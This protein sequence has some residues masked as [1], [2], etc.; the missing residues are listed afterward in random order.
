[1]GETSPKF[2]R[3]IGQP[4][5]IAPTIGDVAG[6]FNRYVKIIWK[7]IVDIFA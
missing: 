5:G 4:Q 1:M 6:A 7:V 3:I 2:T